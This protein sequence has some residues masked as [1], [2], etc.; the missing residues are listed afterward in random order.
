MN[1]P[2]ESGIGLRIFRVLRGSL[3]F[4]I[5][6]AGLL[7]FYYEGQRE[8]AMEAERER[9]I[10]APLR[11]S[12][13]AGEPTIT[14]DEMGQKNSGLWAARLEQA[15]YRGQIQA[16]GTVLDL[17]PLTDLSNS[18]TATKAQLETAQAKRNAS[19]VAFERAERLY[20]DQQNVSA[21][22][23]QAAEAAY[24]VDEA[25]VGAASAQLQNFAATA[26]QLWGPTLGR[27]LVERTPALLRLLERRDVLVQVTLPPGEQLAEPPK[28]AA[29]QV[30]TVK[31]V[32][33]HYVSAAPRTDARIQGVSFYYTAPA[34]KG[35]LPGM[36]V[37][38]VLPS[39]Q[40]GGGKLVPAS[41]IVWSGGKAWA[42]FRTGLETFARREVSTASPAPGGGYV[43]NGIPDDAEAVQLGAQML[44]SEEFRARI[45]VGEEG[46]Q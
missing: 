11:V 45:Q 23:F 17:Q 3:I 46:G 33:I 32:P 21:A 43:V 13:D 27:A 15:P 9:P 40:S 14:L 41:A 25:N 36:N 24:R 30:D 26:A 29:V 1:E 44:L 18:Y 35:L 42:Y 6:G 22:Q 2:T 20:K 31:S 16:F 7:W 19:R 12:V 10:R 37:T 38:A 34:D 28:A 5:L 4:L 8:R 39:G